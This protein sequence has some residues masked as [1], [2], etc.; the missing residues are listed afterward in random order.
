MDGEALR[1]FTALDNAG[2][3]RVLATGNG[4]VAASVLSIAEG[5]AEALAATTTAQGT[6]G[7]HGTQ[8]RRGPTAAAG[9]EAIGAAI[10]AAIEAY[11]GFQQR[12][13]QHTICAASALSEEEEAGEGEASDEDEDEEDGHAGAEAARASDGARGSPDDAQT[14]LSG[15]CGPQTCSGPY[16]RQ[17][18]GSG[19]GE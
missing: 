19:G 3:S 13:L 6:R 7:V 12:V 14:P 17:R 15:A 4:C 10:D 5:L 2:R 1:S 9:D 18:S 11:R 16:K 8:A